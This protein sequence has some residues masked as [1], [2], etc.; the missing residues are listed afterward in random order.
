LQEAPLLH[1]PQAC[2]QANAMKEGLPLHSPLAAQVQQFSLSSFK[3]QPS[4]RDWCRA[5]F[6]IQYSIQRS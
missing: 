5:T 4:V 3:G 2:L 6:S 1:I